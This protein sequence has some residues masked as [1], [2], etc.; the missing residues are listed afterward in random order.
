MDLPL[1]KLFLQTILKHG[2]EI[3]PLA[4]LIAKVKIQEIDLE[5]V[6]I[7]PVVTPIKPPKM[8]KATQLDP[9]LVDVGFSGFT[10]MKDSAV[11]FPT[12]RSGFAAPHCPTATL[13]DEM[14]QTLADGPPGHSI[15]KMDGIQIKAIPPKTRTE[16][17]IK[18]IGAVD[19]SGSGGVRVKRPRLE[20][21]EGEGQLSLYVGWRFMDF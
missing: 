3:N 6:Q 20:R 7:K 19:G 4:I 13:I 16:I 2:F 17:I 10:A 8:E 11:Q 5:E 15:H 14:T 9:P 18:E 21:P 12:M 1:L